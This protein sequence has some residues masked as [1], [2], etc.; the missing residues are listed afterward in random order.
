MLYNKIEKKAFYNSSITKCLTLYGLNALVLVASCQ[1]PGAQD[2]FVSSFGSVLHVIFAGFRITGVGRIPIGVSVL[3]D[4]IPILVS[5][6]LDGNSSVNSKSS[7][8]S[9]FILSRMI[10]S[11]LMYIRKG[12]F[13]DK[14]I[15]FSFC[16]VEYLKNTAKLRVNSFFYTLRESQIVDKNKKC[17]QH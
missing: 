9:S 4:K 1:A 15:H 6:G 12:Y 16:T 5:F 3:L 11:D 13:Q 10:Q 2:F 7:M 14:L 17:Q 8:N